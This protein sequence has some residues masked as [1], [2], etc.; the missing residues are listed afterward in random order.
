VRALG[1]GRAGAVTVVTADTT[2][3]GYASTLRG[4]E[5]AA[6]L[7]GLAVGV[8]VVESDRVDHVRHAVEHVSDPSDRRK[9]T[10]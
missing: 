9:N 10:R 8:R 1:L 6:R 4:I 2:L 5:E 7:A 3:Y